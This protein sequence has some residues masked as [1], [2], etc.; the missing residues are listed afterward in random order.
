MKDDTPDAK[1]EDNWRYV[2]ED[3]AKL[4]PNMV[5]TLPPQ[6]AAAPP[7]SAM[8]NAETANIKVVS[9]TY[10]RNCN[11]KPGNA[12]ALVAKACDGH[13]SCDFM[14]DTSSLEDPA[15]NCEKDFAVEWKCGMAPS[16]TGAV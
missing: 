10:G 7:A 13:G 14:I 12:S 5:A 2:K 15:P 1:G 4:P 11:G 6:A 16:C 8:A 3:Y 9:G